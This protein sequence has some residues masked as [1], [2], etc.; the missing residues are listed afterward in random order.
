MASN[1]HTRRHVTYVTGAH[2]Y[3]VVA[4]KKLEL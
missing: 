3:N 4:Y 2:I 1:G